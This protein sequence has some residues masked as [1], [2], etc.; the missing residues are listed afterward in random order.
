[1]GE[2]ELN[3]CEFRTMEEA[4]W[5]MPILARE[6]YNIDEFSTKKYYF[7]EVKITNLLCMN[8]LILHWLNKNQYLLTL[9]TIYCSLDS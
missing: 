4:A 1:M 3:D 5:T 9:S 2:I 7:G 8:L 6:S